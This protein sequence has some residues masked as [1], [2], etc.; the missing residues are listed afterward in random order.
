MPVKGGVIYFLHTQRVNTIQA[1]YQRNEPPGNT[2]RMVFWRK[3]TCFGS[4]LNNFQRLFMPHTHR[5]QICA[6]DI[7]IA[8]GQQ[9]RF[10]P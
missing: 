7:A 3:L 4:A 8:V 9:L 5:Q 2:F 6:F 1:T 10:A